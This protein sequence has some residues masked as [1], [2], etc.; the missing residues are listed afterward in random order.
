MKAIEKV[1]VS[2]HEHE[3]RLHFACAD[4]V[5]EVQG[6]WLTQRLGNRL[7]VALLAQLD[8]ALAHLP[9]E[10]ARET[11]QTWELSSAR[12]QLMPACP[13]QSKTPVQN[14][15]VTSVD[16]SHANDVFELVFRGAENSASLLNMN[17]TAL[18]QWLHIVH[19]HYRQA[20]WHCTEIWP[21]WFDA[22][23]NTPRPV[24]PG[25]ALH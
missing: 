12:A 5:G 4:N 25:R 21:A 11:V 7:I 18:R 8:G 23:E 3:D 2:Y 10:Y 9:N 16:I 17:K 13:V 15:L 22:E 19:Q 20:G 1:T 24:V 14:D 6:L